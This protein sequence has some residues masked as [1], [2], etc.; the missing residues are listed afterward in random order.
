[1]QVFPFNCTKHTNCNSRKI[2]TCK[3]YEN[4]VY[5][6]LYTLCLIICLKKKREGVRLKLGNIHHYQY[7]WKTISC[8]H[9]NHFW[10]VFNV[11]VAKGLLVNMIRPPGPRP[12]AVR[13]HWSPVLSSVNQCSP[14]RHHTN[15]S[16]LRNLDLH[17]G[18]A[19]EDLQWHFFVVEG[20]R[21]GDTL[22]SLMARWGQVRLH[23]GM[24]PD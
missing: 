8:E 19:D 7:F 22:I 4:Y 20:N 6:F 2:S 5:F 16:A 17:H 3:I 18:V 10:G 21:K 9:Q 1:M 15:N 24:M 11:L 12:S 14:V 23:K 13:G